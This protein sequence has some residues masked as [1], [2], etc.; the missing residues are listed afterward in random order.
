VCEEF[1]IM[2]QDDNYLVTFDHFWSKHRFFK[3]AGAVVEFGTK[4]P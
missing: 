3:A 2:Q 1:R 4:L